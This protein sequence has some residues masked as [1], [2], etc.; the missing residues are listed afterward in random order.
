MRRTVVWLQ[1][2]IGWLPVWAL[3]ATLVLTVHGG[4]WRAA[5][6]LA[7]RMI[8]AAAVLGIFVQRMT[9]RFPWPHP[10]RTSF[11]LLH[12]LGAVL[13]S[14]G[15]LVLNSLI[16]SA[17]HGMLVIAAGPG[18]FPFFVMGIWLYVMV[19]GVTYAT[20]NT[21]RA[22]RAEAAATRAQLA[23]LRTQLNP[24]FLF[25]ALH[26]IVQLIPRE[27][28]RAAQAAERLGG[29]LRDTI[30]E[31]RDLVSLAEERAFVERYL[32]MQRLRFGDRLRVELRLSPGT[33]DVLVPPFSLLTLVENA[34]RHAAEPRA[35]PTDI[36]VRGEL[37]DESLVL[38]VSDTGDGAPRSNG[39]LPGTG[40][41]R[42][43][44]RLV[45][46]YGGRARLEAAP[47]TR[48]YVASLVIPRD[49]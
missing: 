9:E 18:L 32:D 43:R 2:L 20:R 47:G 8:A 24:H 27:P 12:V 38:T 7:T 34:V 15:W 26:T 21:E 14:T 4:S 29:L 40:L 45:A 6:V 10:F 37:R 48:G 1:I 42:L 25:N 5:V 19:T 11:V 39:S 28:Q 16:E 31:E 3:F 36:T 33:E 17:I 23:A 22:A 41:A 13:Y 30:D 44:E 35:E 49:A 46:L